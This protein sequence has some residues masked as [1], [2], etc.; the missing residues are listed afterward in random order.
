M[1]LKNNKTHVWYNKFIHSVRA[2]SL[3]KNK[4]WIEN[5]VMSGNICVKEGKW[6][7]EWAMNY[8]IQ[9][10]QIIDAL[11]VAYKDNWDMHI[12]AYQPE[13]NDNGTK[14]V[15]FSL[16]PI[17]R[18]PHI[19]LTNSR[20]DSTEIKDLIIM[21]PLTV[22]DDFD[23]FNFKIQTILGTRMHYSYDHFTYGF[24]HSHLGSRNQ[25]NGDMELGEFCIGSDSEIGEI[26][27]EIEGNG[28]E[29]N[30]FGL[31][32][33]MIDTIVSWESLEGVPYT[34]MRKVVSD[35]KDNIISHSRGVINDYYSL[36]RREIDTIDATF[37]YNENRYQVKND[38]RL[39]NFVRNFIMTYANGLLIDKLLVKHKDGNYYAPKNVITSSPQ[40]LLAN[41]KQND[42]EL[43]YTF[44]QGQK[45]Y[46][47]V[48]PKKI[49]EPINLN[50]YNVYPKFLT[51]VT[52]QLEKE[53]YEK[54]VRSSA[55]ARQAE[56]NNA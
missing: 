55:I 56:F 42:N 37:I 28:F 46:L 8:L 26:M 10:N 1:H 50:E 39:N 15:V 14:S 43:P 45:V 30:L 9:M 41:A 5:M 31:Y 4:K 34:E 54:A 22:N 19:T 25:E 2:L 13:S 35:D 40:E 44:I 17:I 18:Y 24:V 3:S 16:N 48:T 27:L 32:L 52:K 36:F 6:K 29:E 51:Y 33:T 23:E 20:D 7:D 38:E 11:N 53:L 21:I 47:Q 49:S 12:R